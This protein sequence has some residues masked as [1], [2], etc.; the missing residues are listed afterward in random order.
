MGQRVVE[1]LGERFKPSWKHSKSL[2]SSCLEATQVD[3]PFVL[4][5]PDCFMNESGEPVRLL[6]NH[7]KIDFKS[8]LLVVMDDA[9]LPLGRLRLRLSG[10]DGGHR[11]LR[12]IESALGS[13]DYARLRVGIGPSAPVKTPLEK[14]VLDP[15]TASEEA[16]LKREFLERA[17]N[18]SLFWVT[19]L[20][21]RA[22]NETNKPAS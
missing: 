3:V 22:M 18:A 7:F 9:A 16:K 17:L 13:R 19:E 6:V 10:T 5:V 14:Y 15:F 20:P 4:A 8:G 21:E 11:G 12:S 2:R 1:A